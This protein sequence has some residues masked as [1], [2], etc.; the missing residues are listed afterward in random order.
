M[1][2][3]KD[4]LKKSLADLYITPTGTLLVHSSMKSIGQVNGGADTVLDT[5][6]EYMKGG[7]LVFPTHTWKYIY[8]KETDVFDWRHDPACVG[9]LPNIFMK[10]KGAVRSIHPTH[11]VAAMGK[12]ALDFVNGEEN[13]DT[14]CGRTGCWGKLLDK[15]AKI[16]F[17]GCGTDRNTI[18]HGFEEWYNV[19]NRI[20]NHY[21]SYKVVLRDGSIIERPSRIH[22]TEPHIDIS[23]NYNILETPMLETGIAVEGKFGNAR[24]IV[25]DVFPM[26][27]FVGKVLEHDKNIFA[28][29]NPI[30]KEWYL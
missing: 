29:S 12:D 15:K 16:M 11:S 8:G 24:C 27:Q 25:C 7:L 1:I 13:I 10:R 2:Y 26:Y 30:P 9:L 23:E 19:P 17:L 28:N 5:L 21:E 3:T 20:S 22:K 4:M 18:I 6:C 14:P